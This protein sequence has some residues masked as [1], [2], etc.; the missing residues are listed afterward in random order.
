[1]RTVSTAVVSLALLLTACGSAAQVTASPSQSGAPIESSAGVGDLARTFP[2]C[3]EGPP[4]AGG[5]R[6]VQQRTHDGMVGVIRN[7]SGARIFA[8]GAS[9]DWCSLERGKRAAYALSVQDV[10]Q[11]GG[12]GGTTSAPHVIEVQLDLA[13][14]PLGY[15][16][17]KVTSIGF[18]PT[19]P[20]G[21]TVPGDGKKV[22][23]KEGESKELGGIGLGT[24]SAQ[25]LP[26]DKNAAREWS[27]VD[28]WEVDDWARVDL[29]VT[30]AA[31]CL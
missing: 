30:A 31:K 17:V 11:L 10:V 8:K 14:D 15:P 21:C 22:E 3:T 1:M 20:P 24:L 4:A 29:T 28:S 18:K 26:D 7:E 9:G 12:A 25:R 5:L 2:A 16:Y 19:A 23:L 13:D 27:G 6:Q